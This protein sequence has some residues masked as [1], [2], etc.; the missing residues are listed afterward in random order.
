MFQY[1]S[2]SHLR[3]FCFHLAQQLKSG[4]QEVVVIDM[5]GLKEL[6]SHEIK[7][8]V[9][10]LGAGLSIADLTELSNHGELAEGT[11]PKADCFN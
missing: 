6:K 8:G 1:G 2:F 5:S 4:G 11:E 7:D 9:L 10:M 3:L